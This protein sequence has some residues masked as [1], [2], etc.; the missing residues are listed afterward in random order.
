MRTVPG[1]EARDR[2][3]DQ[4]YKSVVTLALFSSAVSLI[5]WCPSTNTS[6]S[7]Q[8]GLSIQL[9][10]DIDWLRSTVQLMVWWAFQWP[11]QNFSQTFFPYST[12]HGDICILKHPVLSTFHLHPFE[13]D[14]MVRS[15]NIRLNA[16]SSLFAWR[17][18]FDPWDRAVLING[19]LK[20]NEIGRRGRIR[21][22]SALL[23]LKRYWKSLAI[24][25]LQV[26]QKC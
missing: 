14:D 5:H 6:H 2:R 3:D 1:H 18:E 15:S 11:H 20:Y 16:K 22:N 4:I 21:W 7:F 19:D 26:V 8:I 25:N 13:N 9:R 17:H 24:G 10:I 12:D 23:W